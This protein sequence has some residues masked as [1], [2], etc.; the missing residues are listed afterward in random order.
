[1]SKV[2]F[3]V[4]ND[5]GDEDTWQTYDIAYGPYESLERACRKA[6]AENFHSA[7]IVKI[8]DGVRVEK[9]GS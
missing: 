4:I 8:V 3:A 2:E 7:S 9:V 6:E 1:M 5:F